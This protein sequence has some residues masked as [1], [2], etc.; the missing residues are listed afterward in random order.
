[1]SGEWPKP[2]DDIREPK[3]DSMFADFSDR[4]VDMGP[5]R[6]YNDTVY[7]RDNAGRENIEYN[8]GWWPLERYLEHYGGVE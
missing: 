2:W 6:A 1:M 4:W 8:D 3:D 5:L 7:I